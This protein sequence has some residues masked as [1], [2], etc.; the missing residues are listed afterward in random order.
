MKKSIKIKRIYDDFDKHDGV[1][2]LIDRLWPRGMKKENAHID[3]WMKELAPSND[4]RQWFGHEPAKWKEFKR[5][6]FGELNKNKDLCRELLNK[7]KT[8][9]TLLYA[10][11]DEEHNNAAA[12]KDY[13]EKEF[14]SK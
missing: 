1:R 3:E 4:L 6:Y 10:A 8:N 13:L 14:N 12:L 5:K 9:I 2:I 7:G 11:K